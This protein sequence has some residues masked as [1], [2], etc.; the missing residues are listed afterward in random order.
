MTMSLRANFFHASPS[1]SYTN[2]PR[3]AN[4]ISCPSLETNPKK[5]SSSSTRS[6]KLR[7]LSAHQPLPKP[8]S[9]L[10]AKLPSTQSSGPKA[11][12]QPNCRIRVIKI[13]V[14]PNSIN[15]LLIFSYSVAKAKSHN[16]I[17]VPK[18]PARAK[19]PSSYVDQNLLDINS[20]F[21]FLHQPTV[22]HVIQ[23]HTKPP[24]TDLDCNPEFTKIKFEQARDQE[25]LDAHLKIGSHVPPPIRI[26]LTELIK[27]TG[28]AST[29]T[30]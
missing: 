3:K 18:S 21:E 20:G 14:A 30:A 4:Q 28:A 12:H 10:Q 23:K 8:Q 1:P 2:D 25:Y 5:A 26:K 6:N 27:N 22:G 24:L 9:H 13:L 11:R 19:R 29:K 16:I 7:H 15:H 17:R